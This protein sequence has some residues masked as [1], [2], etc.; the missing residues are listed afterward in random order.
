[1]NMRD[2]EQSI[3]QLLKLSGERHAPSAERAAQARKAVYESWQ[4]M[5]EQNKKIIRRRRWL[6]ASLALAA[7]MAGLLVVSHHSLPPVTP[8][9]ARVVAT[10]GDVSITTGADV[11]AGEQLVMN[12]GRVALTLGNS[13]SLRV[14]QHTKLRIDATDRVTLLRGRIYVDSGGLST[15]ATLMI[16]TPAGEVQHLGTQFQVYVQDDTTRVRVREG[17]VQLSS[18][19]VNAQQVNAQQIASGEELQIVGSQVVLQRGLPTY[20]TDWEWASTI[21]PALDIENRPL[22]EFLTW[23]AREHG[24]QLRYANESVQQRTHEIRLHGSL[25]QMNSTDVVERISLIT[26]VPIVSQEGVLLVGKQKGG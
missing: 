9:V 17:H 2:P 1:M 16:M 24:W 22:A 13:L 15:N 14:D 25:E 26:G 12:M 23:M 8:T 19:R 6:K 21:A 4:Q 20:G 10:E 18:R 5:L 11:H 3:A 7:C